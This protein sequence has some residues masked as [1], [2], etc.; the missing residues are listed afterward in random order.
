MMSELYI[1]GG[2][3]LLG[4][5]CVNGAKNSVLPILAATII[6]GGVNEIHNCPDLKDVQSAIKILRHLGCKV[7]RSHD[8]V[9]VDSAGFC[10][11]DIPDDLMREMRSSVIFLGPILAR[12]GKAQMTF[13][14]GCEIGP[15]PIDLHLAALKKMGVRITENYGELICECENP[16]GCEI[17]LSLPSVGATEN[18]MLFA[19]ACR[20]TTTIV[21][22][23]REPEIRD[24]QEFLAKTGAKIH[25][26]G[27]HDIEICG[28]KTRNSASHTVMSDRIEASTYLCAC[29][30]A[31]G[32]IE[33]TGVVP[34]HFAA[35]SA[36]LSSAG[37]IIEIGK[38][39]ITIAAPKR[40]SSVAIVRTMPY[41]GFPTD[42]QS[43]L[44]ASLCT[45]NGT[46]VFLENMFDNRYRHC[47]ELA[48]MGA[49]IRIEGK[50][51]IVSGVCS[52][53][54]A[55]VASTDLR[56]GAAMVVA[57]LGA[58][59]ESV[60]SQIEHIDRGYENIERAFT[61]IG[62]NIIRK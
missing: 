11:Y 24:L 61:S 34:S 43:P 44:M 22:A 58:Q 10:R 55:R 9:T 18:I 54:G 56:G 29:A 5:V 53:T 3:P 16:V 39:Q 7:E 41:P 33:V 40:L 20:G 38:S 12:C 59:G 45:A 51:A 35:V 28:S 26:A 31:G 13:P 2:N 21:N 27:C 1:T 62:A 36:I 42:A 37:C 25:G 46:T 48:R 52:L 49:N 17:S 23:A 15:R 4:S 6:N 32:K 30:A 8:V 57:A 19:T 50:V 60:I 47:A 14:G